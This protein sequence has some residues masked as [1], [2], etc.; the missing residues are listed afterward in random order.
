MELNVVL[1][2]ELEPCCTDSTIGYFRDGFWRY[3]IPR[4]MCY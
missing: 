4:S 3:R 2:T 1:G